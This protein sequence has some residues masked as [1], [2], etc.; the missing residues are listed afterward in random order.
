MHMGTKLGEGFHP[1]FFEPFDREKGNQANQ[2]ADAKL[3]VATVGIAPARLLLAS[4]LRTR[5]ADA[6]RCTPH[7]I[8]KVRAL[9]CAC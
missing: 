8:S 7:G 1:A 6:G 3:V 5:R 4:V 2:R 9:A